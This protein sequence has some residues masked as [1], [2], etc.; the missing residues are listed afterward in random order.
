MSNYIDYQGSLSFSPELSDDEHHIVCCI[1]QYE[2][3]VAIGAGAEIY[4][5]TVNFSSSYKLGYNLANELNKCTRLIRLLIPDFH[6]SGRLLLENSQDKIRHL[7]IN[8][9]GGA[10]YDGRWRD[11]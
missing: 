10:Y 11:G 5:N 3:D 4:E 9:E 2:N 8:L 6:F 1:L 7:L